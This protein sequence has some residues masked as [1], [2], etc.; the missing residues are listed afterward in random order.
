MGLQLLAPVL[1][2]GIA[3]VVSAV[4]LSLAGYAPTDVLTAIRDGGFERERLVGM[5]NRAGPYYI[6]AVAVAVGFKMNLFNIGVEGQYKLGALVAAWAGALVALP[7]PLHVG[8]ILLVAM[9]VGCLYA[10]I[11]AVLK[12]TRGVSEVISSIMLNSIAFGIASYLLTTYFRAPAG[13]FAGTIGTVPLDSSALLPSLNGLLSSI[14][15][16]LPASASVQSYVLVAVAVGI[17]YHVI[18][19]RTRFGYDLRASGSNPEAAEASGVNPRKMILKAMGLSG[20]F[21]GL[22]ALNDVLGDAGRYT[23]VSVVRGLG[24]TGIAVALLGRN[25]PIGIAFGA[26]LWSFMDEIQVPLSTADLPKQITS[27]L[28][29]VTVLSVVVAYEVVRRITSRQQAASMRRDA[30]SA[31]APPSAPPSN[32]EV[33]TA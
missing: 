14:G 33:A 32:P 31:A 13:E 22:V 10:L 30:P 20:A 25:N 5:I 21:A 24:F 16:D 6:S 17:A 11:P 23:D 18:V 12:A 8:F 28:Q 3:I 26:L 7:A 1:A 19:W 27:I 9:A 2:V 15:I 4:I 29:G